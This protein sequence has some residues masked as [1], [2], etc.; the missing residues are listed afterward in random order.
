MAVYF[1]LLILTV[2]PAFYCV[3][4]E[5]D[6]DALSISDDSLYLRNEFNHNCFVILT[7]VMIFFQSVRAITVGGDLFDN[8]ARIYSAISKMSWY[9]LFHGAEGYEGYEIGYRVFNKVVSSLFGDNISFLL[10]S[11]AFVFHFSLF[12]L[13]EKN[14]D[15]YCFSLFIVYCLGMYNISMNNLRSSIALSIIFWGL[16]YAFEGRRAI[17]FISIFIASLFHLTALC[18]LFYFVTLLIKNKRLLVIFL[19]GVAAFLTIGYGFIVSLILRFFPRYSNYFSMSFSD[20]GF[21]YL[22]FLTAILVFVFVFPENGFFDDEK[23]L[24]LLKLLCCAIVLQL[25]SLRIP[26]FVRAVNYHLIG[27][28]IL[29]PDVLED[30]KIKNLGVY[31]APV[32]MVFFCA[33]YVYS[34]L[35]G[36]GT[37]TIPYSFIWG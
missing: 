27:V 22:I 26:F 9:T 7:I 16:N 18:F 36:N 12:K 20:G 8:Y 32:L 4:Y 17:F 29:L 21:N 1:F 37:K 2:I 28:S 3:R 23:R 25:L 5:I 6:K 14:S 30:G 33:F 10:F 31:I 15:N 11:I 19:S 13:I 35:I 34:I 24:C